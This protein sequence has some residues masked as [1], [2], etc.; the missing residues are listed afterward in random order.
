MPGSAF[1][2]EKLQKASAPQCSFSIQHMTFGRYNCL[3]ML[4]SFSMAN[5]TLNV[6][7]FHSSVFKVEH[8]LSPEGSDPERLWENCR[9]DITKC[10]SKQLETLNGNNRTNIMICT[11]AFFSVIY[12]VSCQYSHLYVSRFQERAA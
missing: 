12:V 6:I 11:S 2:H 5:I 10:D 7:N 8:V 4:L 1:F 3:Y 9:L